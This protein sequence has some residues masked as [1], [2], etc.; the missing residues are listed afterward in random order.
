MYHYPN[1]REDDPERV[2]PVIKAYPLGLIVSRADGQFRASHI[3][4][5]V[6][7]GVGGSWRLRGHMDRNNPQ[8]ADLDGASVYVVFQ[9][10]NAY[11]SPS[12]YVTRQLPTW[13]YV[14]VHVEGRCQVEIP[15][16]GIL[17][18]IARL[19]QESERHEDGWVLDKEDSRVRTLAPLIGRILVEIE[20][21][22]GRFKLSQEKSPA[23]RD[24]ATAHLVERV[25][26][27]A[28]PLVEDLSFGRKP[29]VDEA[30]PPTA[31]GSAMTS[32]ED[33]GSTN[34]D[35]AV[36]GFDVSQGLDR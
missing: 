30:L 24:A 12:V 8:L 36:A 6:E 29:K 1:Y 14:A 25:G 21:M 19:A 35:T 32:T 20:Q 23:D 5:V 15:G 18:D 34:P 13:N 28:R 33:V 16:L 27:S 31:Y 22:E 10:P 9:A 26:L 2:I 7:Q 11:I 17:D 4:F 3:P